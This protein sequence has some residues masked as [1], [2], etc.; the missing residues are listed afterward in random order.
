MTILDPERI[1]RQI[2]KDMQF[3]EQLQMQIV[4]QYRTKEA[5]REA[6]RQMARGEITESASKLLGY[7]ELRE[8]LQDVDFDADWELRV[9]R[10]M[11][12]QLRAELVQEIEALQEY[13][14]QLERRALKAEHETK[15]TLYRPTN[16]PSAQQ[17]NKVRREAADR[18]TDL[19]YIGRS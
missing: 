16:Q 2:E 3:Y 15:N 10:N 19:R 8:D 5:K 9:R 13:V 12:E 11:A 18:L 4:E 6:A 14:G 7:G 17:S 1:K